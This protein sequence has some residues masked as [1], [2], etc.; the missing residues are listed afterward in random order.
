[1]QTERLTFP[2]A[3]GGSL[4]ARLEIPDRE[5]TTYAL[6][7]HCFTCSKNLKAAANISRA[8]GKESIG[9]LRFDFTGLG[10]SEGNFADTTFSSNVD[11]LV[12]AATFMNERYASPTLL[13]GHSLGGA[14][15]LLA[16]Q[17]VNSVKAVVTIGAPCDPEHVKEHFAG[18]VDDIEKLGAVEVLLGGRRFTIKKEFLDDLEIHN[19]ERVIGTLNRAL[20]I[21][22]SPVDE[23]VS[24]DNASMIYSAAKHP[25]SFVSLDDADH[26]LNREED[27]V[28]AARVIAAW[29]SRYTDAF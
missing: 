17:H 7:A 27:S 18:S 21:M 8:L 28:Y 12:A 13:I 26:L 10:E 1:M 20:L 25:K 23:V 19:M 4:S 16:A 15:A 5:S 14:A 22:H 24:I 11:D 9:V 6:F 3:T 29:A 2:G